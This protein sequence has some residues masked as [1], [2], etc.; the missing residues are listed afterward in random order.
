MKK[1]Y[2]IFFFLF[3]SI[4][5]FGLDRNTFAEPNDSLY[6][7]RL[8][9]M[10]TLRV[11]SGQKFSNFGINDRE[12]KLELAFKANPSSSIGIGGSYKWISVNLGIGVSN[13]LDSVFG[14]ARKI[15][16]QTNLYLRNLRINIYSSVYNGFYLKNTKDYLANS[17][18]YYRPDIQTKTFGLSTLYVV[19][20]KRYSTKA[21]FLQNEWQK[22]TAGSL[23][24]GGSIIYN[25][26]KADSTLIPYFAIDNNFL[27]GKGFTKNRYFALG[28]NAGY[29]FTLV[30]MKRLFLD[31]SLMGGFAYGNTTIRTVENDEFSSL[32]LK[33]TLLN[34]V[35]FGY[36]GERLYVGFNY[37]GFMTGAPLPFKHAGMNLNVGKVRF[38][39]AYRFKIKE[40]ANILPVWMPFEL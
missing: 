3:I 24:I 28:G 31:F 13:S 5:T 23:V 35:G 4:T 17:Q 7:S 21:T 2:W 33:L 40:H 26:I 10:F 16:F 34:T 22:K 9:N 14:E 30:I 29:A 8:K 27:E 18:Y 11:F 25:R 19:N 39:L 12:N 36:N 32:K 20:S 38:V 1:Y 37:S 6:Y 15:D